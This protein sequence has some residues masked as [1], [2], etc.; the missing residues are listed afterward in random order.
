MKRPINRVGDEIR[1]GSSNA[2]SRQ[3]NHTA[4]SA[5]AMN[6]WREVVAGRMKI[7]APHSPLALFAWQRDDAAH[8]DRCIPAI[9]EARS[10]A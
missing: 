10:L 8:I 4:R 7:R 5:G 9:S 6:T 3:L 2:I 1:E